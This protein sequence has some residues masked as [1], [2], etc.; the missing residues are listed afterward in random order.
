MKTVFA[1][2]TQ[3]KQSRGGGKRDQHKIPN[4]YGHINQ[5][6]RNYDHNDNH[7]RSYTSY[8]RDHNHDT[9]ARN[10]RGRSPS[11]DRSNSQRRSPR[12]PSDSHKDNYRQFLFLRGKGTLRETQKPKCG[13]CRSNNQTHM[14]HIKKTDGSNK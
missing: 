2:K 14:S 8:D 3:S 9:R 11:R 12:S 6:N 5:Q 10:D 1:G 7:K 4:Q 13:Q